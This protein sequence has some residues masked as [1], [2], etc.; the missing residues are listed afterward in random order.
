MLGRTNRI[1]ALALLAFSMLGAAKC[2]VKTTTRLKPE[3]VRPLLTAT[4][5]ELLEQLRLQADGVHSVN[6]VAE[7]VPSTGSAYSGVIEQYRDVRA[8]VLARNS[9]MAS[10]GSPASPSRAQQIRMIGQAPIV[11]KTIFDMVADDHTFRILV[12]SK[13]KFIVGPTALNRRSDKPIENLRPQHLLEALLPAPPRPGAFHLWNE[14]EFTGRRYYAV[15]ELVSV[16]EDD[17]RLARKWW[18]DRT[19]LALVRLQRFDPGGRLLA[20]IH[21]D[22][23][24]E[25]G[26]LAYPRQI[27]LIRPHDDYRIKLLIKELTLNEPLAAEKFRL[28]KPTGVDLVELKEKDETGSATAVPGAAQEAAR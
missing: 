3:Q 26:E 8:F 16:A 6:A 7:L 22:L 12:P 19:D 20:D 14:N 15:S 27:E 18:F 10:S 1:A 11:R 17:W 24:Q 28:E 4:L 25:E 13:K 9:T 21:Y 23:W 5:E 2:G